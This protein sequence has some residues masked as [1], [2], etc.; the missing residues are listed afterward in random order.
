MSYDSKSILPIKYAKT[1]ELHTSLSIDECKN[2]IFKNTVRD[3]GLLSGF[4]YH[5]FRAEISGNAFCLHK[6][7]GKNSWRVKFAAKFSQQ[8]DATYVAGRFSIP[9]LVEPFMSCMLISLILFAAPIFL[10]AIIDFFNK[11]KFQG[12]PFTFLF[13]KLP[14]FFVLP[15]LLILFRAIQLMGRDSIPKQEETIIAFLQKHLQATLIS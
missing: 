9:A 12:S 10:W 11:W 1:V 15:L 3:Y 6:N 4:D 5:E 8:G 14:V 7:W 2:R 13:D